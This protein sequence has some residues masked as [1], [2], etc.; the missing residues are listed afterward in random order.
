MRIAY[1]YD[2]IKN[3][4]VLKKMENGMFANK[5]TVHDAF[6]KTITTH[7]FDYMKTFDDYFHTESGSGKQLIPF[8]KF[9]NT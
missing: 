9:D 5:L 3:V 7:E 8:Q 4:D 2:L 6:N 1:N